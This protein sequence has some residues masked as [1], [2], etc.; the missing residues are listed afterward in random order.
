MV[1]LDAVSAHGEWNS[2]ADYCLGTLPDVCKANIFRFLFK[3]KVGKDRLVGLKVEAEIRNGAA[4][5]IS[6]WFSG[7]RLHLRKW[8]VGFN[9]E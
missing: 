6:S 2:D 9:G 4:P 8:S 7:E 1:S 3:K 5:F